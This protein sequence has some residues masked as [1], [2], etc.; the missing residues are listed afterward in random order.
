M[1]GYG[2][3]LIVLRELD[4]DVAAVEA[5]LPREIDFF[6]GYE[7]RVHEIMESVMQELEN[8]P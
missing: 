3:E 2:A 8:E 5:D 1:R 4:G 7:S 6:I